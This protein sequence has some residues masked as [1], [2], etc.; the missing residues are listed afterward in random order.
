M[1]SSVPAIPDPGIAPVDLRAYLKEQE[2]AL[3]ERALAVS[4][5]HQAKAADLLGLSYDQLRG[6]LRKHDLAGR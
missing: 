1:E 3:T 5:G 6:I 4:S 2:K